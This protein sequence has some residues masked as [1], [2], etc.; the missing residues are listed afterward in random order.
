MILLNLK[1]HK[2]PCLLLLAILLVCLFFWLGSR[3][4]GLNDKA[5][6]GNEV[7][8]Q[9]IG[10]DTILEPQNSSPVW[11]QVIIN[12]VNWV[13]TNWRGMVFGFFVGSL[14]L[15]FIPYIQRY[16]FK[17][18]SLN[19]IAGIAVGAPLG[20][21]VNCATPIAQ[22]MLASGSRQE[23]ALATLISSPTLNI[24][25]LTMSFSILPTHLALL[26]VIMTLG[27]V[28]C[29][30]PMVVKYYPLLII[31]DQAKNKTS[32]I[33]LSKQHFSYEEQSWLN[34][35]VQASRL[36]FHSLYLIVLKTL[37]LMLFAGFLGAIIITILP[38]ESL[39]TVL[40]SNRL[41]NMLISIAL[42][43][44]L[45]LFLP[46]PMAF[47]VIVVAILLNMG[48]PMAY[49]M[50]L[51]FTLGIFSIYP[52]M[53]IW[54]SSKKASISLSTG[55]MLLAIMAG[56]LADRYEVLH[57]E[58]QQEYIIS[59]FANSTTKERKTNSERVVNSEPHYTLIKRISEYS[60]KYRQVYIDDNIVINKSEHLSRNQ[61]EASNT[62]FIERTG[63][64]VGISENDNFSV[65]KLL[66]RYAR[67]RGV[68]VG[69][70][71][72]DGWTDIA[73]ASESGIGLYINIGGQKFTQQHINIPSL[74]DFYIASIAIID[75]DNNGWKDIVFSTF[76]RGVYVIH[77]F[78]GGFESQNM[79]LLTENEDI[80]VTNALTF[81]D[82]DKN[83][84]LDIHLGNASVGNAFSEGS[85]E[86]SR[87]IMLMQF[88]GQF[89]INNMGTIP[90]ETLSALVTDLNSDGWPDLLVANEFEVSDAVFLNDG[91]GK[92]ELLGPDQELFP[93]T[94][95]TT[96]SI[97]S[98]DIDNDLD[99]ELYIAQRS[100]FEQPQ[101]LSNEI[102]CNE[103]E[104]AQEER[105]C[106]E[107]LELR[108]IRLEATQRKDFKHCET[109]KSAEL[110]DNCLALLVV[111]H[112]NPR[113]SNSKNRCHYLDENWPSMSR[114][115]ERLFGALATPNAK[116]L[117]LEL[118]QIKLKNLLF[119]RTDEGAYV[120]ISDNLG[121]AH[122]GWSWNSDF[123]DL[124][125]DGWQDLFIV[126]GDLMVRTRHP[127]YLFENRDGKKFVN[128]TT[129]YGLGSMRD[130]LSYSFIDSDHD[131]DLD[132]IALPAAGTPVFYENTNTNNNSLSIELVDTVG[133]R[134][135]V[136]SKITVYYEN[137]QQLREI[138]A[139]GGFSS[140]NAPI[141]HFG[142]GK[143]ENVNRVDI[144][145]SDGDVNQIDFS[146]SA[147]AKYQITRKSKKSKIVAFK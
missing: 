55:I 15:C 146:F 17:S 83:G 29:I 69:D 127:N 86:V 73:I 45:G 124:N 28:L 21:C 14:L 114:Y 64:S 48:L 63:A 40:P 27:V 26:K 100:W 11:Q 107:M 119:D 82:F 90:G 139:S 12:T 62:L 91:N 46:V 44:A 2:V 54:R 99:I 23:T 128:N 33:Q 6:M 39:I 98:A 7:D 38:L 60:L 122:G 87:N 137:G 30:V 144:A 112:S 116:Q 47:D 56:I 147:G 113:L 18:P 49:A 120:N 31:N 32:S 123:A 76:E 16:Q 10:F 78:S 115:C 92:L 61:T 110:I 111:H 140:A 58:W 97:T 95:R 41:M 79:Q 142:L 75:L 108:N 3:Y 51:L 19:A 65:L 20:V 8:I 129:K 104:A 141:A 70:V 68:A 125:N 121:I 25:V 131:G 80:F 5:L 36:F 84:E 89:E 118:S 34:A 37:P 145:W 85:Y 57:Q 59:Q 102:V 133:N 71:H 77:N 42:L 50:V 143:T 94:A 105:V 93:F 138:K 24:V 72:N 66:A 4:P 96:M 88:D 132:I 130:F 126:T 136:G 22:G 67:S 134:S 101:T 117:S 53:I 135:G 35:F 52:F 74:S 103:I 1:R 43:A 109:L 81:A 9:A 13:Y 106:R